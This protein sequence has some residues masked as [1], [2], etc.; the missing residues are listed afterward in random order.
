MFEQSMIAKAPKAKRIWAASLGVT[1]QATL[2]GAMILAPMLWPETIPR[3]TFTTLVPHAPPGTHPREKGDARP[4]RTPRMVR[5]FRQEGLFQPR[6]IPVGAPRIEDPLTPMD[7]GVGVPYGTGLPGGGDG[8]GHFFDGILTTTPEP[9]K[10]TP[11]P[12]AAERPKPAETVIERRKVGGFVREPKLV[13]RVDPRYPDIAAR[14]GI[15]GVVILTGVIGVDGRIRELSVVS[16]NPL[17]AP[18]ALAAV[19]QWLYQPTLLNG[20]P[21]EVETQ[22]V[23]TFK[24][25]R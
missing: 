17:L 10:P 2:V 24:L 6:V 9:P 23:V 11:V 15:S 4:R 16:G 1:G 25:S 20:D 8:D 14:A 3:V 19:R 21:I 5:V 18:A 13:Y 7:P 12:R 22:I